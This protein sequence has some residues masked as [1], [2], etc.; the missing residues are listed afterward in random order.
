MVG[1]ENDVLY[2]DIRRELRPYT[3]LLKDL[4]AVLEPVSDGN[5]GAPIKAPVQRVE[6]LSLTNPARQQQPTLE[7]R[8]R[9]DRPAIAACFEKL[10]IGSCK[11]YILSFERPTFSEAEAA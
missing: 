7:L 9:K 3:P 1:P 11:T 2:P 8:Y 10:D 6:T 5:L 4:V